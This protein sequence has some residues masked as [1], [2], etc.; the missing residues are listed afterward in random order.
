ML[1]SSRLVLFQTDM[2]SE[3]IHISLVVL[4]PEAITIL[5]ITLRIL[6]SARQPYEHS[7]VRLQVLRTMT[8]NM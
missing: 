7:N 2:S 4:H 1:F 6:Q 3:I 8:V 5:P